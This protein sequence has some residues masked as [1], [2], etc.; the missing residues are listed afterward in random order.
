[1]PIGNQRSS[2]CPGLSTHTSRRNTLP[3]DMFS[4]LL[5]VLATPLTKLIFIA[6]F[7]LTKSVSNICR[8]KYCDSGSCKRAVISCSKVVSA[9]WADSCNGLFV[10]SL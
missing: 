9:A 3:L 6:A 8:R 1:M 5:N 2:S 10:H 7:K 4:L